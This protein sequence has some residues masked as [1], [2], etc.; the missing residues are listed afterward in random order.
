M[1]GRSIRVVMIT[2]A[3]K[4]ISTPRSA[5]ISKGNPRHRL[6]PT[7]ATGCAATGLLLDPLLHAFRQALRTMIIPRS[8]TRFR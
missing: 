7:R 8:E 5:Q 3:F 6:A 2:T 4:N 1:C